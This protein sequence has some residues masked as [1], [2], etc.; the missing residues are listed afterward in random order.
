MSVSS[1]KKVLLELL[2]LQCAIAVV[3]TCPRV[4]AESPEQ[5]RDNIRRQLHHI[6]KGVQ[7]SRHRMRAR[8]GVIEGNILRGNWGWACYSDGRK[9]ERIAE[10]NCQ[11]NGGGCERLYSVHIHNDTP[12]TIRIYLFHPWESDFVAGNALFQWRWG[13]GEGANMA[14]SGSG[15]LLAPMRFYLRAEYS[16]DSSRGWGPKRISEFNHA[17]RNYS[18]GQN[19]RIRLTP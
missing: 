2:I 17:V 15:H 13:P 12:H 6:A 14:L 7:D 9:A 5:T 18:D 11:K 4:A 10:D 8:Y 1:A 19:L 3:L 16:D